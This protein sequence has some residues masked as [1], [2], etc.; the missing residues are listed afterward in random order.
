MSECLRRIKVSGAQSWPRRCPRC[1]PFGA[2]NDPEFQVGGAAI[3]ELIRRTRADRD[4]TAEK[5]AA[6]DK[7][8][9]ILL[10]VTPHE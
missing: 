1:G 4:A 6:L 2:C 9:D 5:L 8:L 7:E 3:K 10:S